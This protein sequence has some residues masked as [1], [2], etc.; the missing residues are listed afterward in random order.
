MRIVS[1][2][3][4]LTKTIA[5]AGMAESLVGVTNFCVDPIKLNNSVVRIGGTKDPVLDEISRLNPTHIITNDEENLKQDVEQLQEI[6]PV[7][8]CFPKDAKTTATALRGMGEYLSGNSNLS[9][10]ADRIEERLE[11]LARLPI[12][13]KRRQF[14]YFIWKRPYMIAGR[15]TYISNMLELAGFENAL[16]DK[17]ARYP[18]VE[19]S[20]LMRGSSSLFLMSSEPYPFRLRDVNELRQK[21]G[22]VDDV[23]R[24]DG[25]L[26]SWYG[27]ITLQ[28]LEKIISF[29]SQKETNLDL[30]GFRPS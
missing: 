24:V 18:E 8:R 21:L 6:C 4:S 19:E 26:W 29:R 1:L 11:L 12:V 14:F 25:K 9:G 22:G 27:D 3:P 16:A 17:E 30:L 10:L 13:S 20:Q 15:D 28:L 7:F 5:A 23:F 2:V